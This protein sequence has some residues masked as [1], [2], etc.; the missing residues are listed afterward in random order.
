MSSDNASEVDALGD[1]LESIDSAQ[2]ATPPPPQPEHGGG[3]ESLVPQVEAFVV[4]LGEAAEAIKRVTESLK[5]YHAKARHEAVP[6]GGRSTRPR[7]HVPEQASS[8]MEV[9]RQAA[10]EQAQVVMGEEREQN[11]YRADMGAMPFDPGELE[12]IRHKV[13][14]AMPAARARGLN[15]GQLVSWAMAMQADEI[16]QGLTAGMEYHVRSQ[17]NINPRGGY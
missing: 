14:Q 10:A 15:L 1:K 5:A 13:T 6:E 9:T 17:Q 7:H 2:V 16:E 12:Q 8:P 4:K 11:Q 3:L